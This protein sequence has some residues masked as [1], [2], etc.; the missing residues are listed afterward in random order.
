MAMGEGGC[1]AGCLKVGFAAWGAVGA[2]AGN[3]VSQVGRQMSS[4]KGL[5]LQAQHLSTPHAGTGI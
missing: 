1:W 2:G 5:G 3:V 4:E